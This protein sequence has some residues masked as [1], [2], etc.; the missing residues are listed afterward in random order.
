MDTLHDHFP[1]LFH[2]QQVYLTKY[3]SEQNMFWTQLVQKH[4]T[5]ILCPV[6]FFCKYDRFP[7]N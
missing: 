4:E 5:H 2:M 3:I 7:D 6:K 1:P